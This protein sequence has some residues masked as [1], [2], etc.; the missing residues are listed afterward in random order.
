MG[1]GAYLLVDKGQLAIGADVERPP[2]RNLS[3]T[4]D[5]AVG[6]GDLLLGVTENRIIQLQRFCI[7]FVGRGIVAAG[8]KE[9]DLELVQ[10]R[11]GVRCDFKLFVA[12]QGDGERTFNFAGTQRIALSRSATGKRF[13][14]PSQYNG[15]SLQVGQL[16]GLAVT[17]F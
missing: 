14:E 9:S 2:L 7:L 12:E 17:A 4:V 1:A 8:G 3:C 16:V 5:D 11:S 15:L 6:F 13:R 10:S